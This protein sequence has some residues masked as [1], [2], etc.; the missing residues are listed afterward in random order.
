[1][2]ANFVRGKC[3]PTLVTDE[4]RAK[5]HRKRNPNYPVPK[6]LYFLDVMAQHR[7]ACRIYIAKSSVS[8]YIYADGLGVSVKLRFSE[9]PPSKQQIENKE[10]DI[11][12]GVSSLYTCTTE[13]AIVAT[14]KKLGVVREN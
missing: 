5:A 4:F 11:Y 3:E 9:H 7:V 2:K 10:A 1:M 6:W 12:V 14:L 8:K 13:M